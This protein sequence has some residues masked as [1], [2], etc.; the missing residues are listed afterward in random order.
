[1]KIIVGKNYQ[2]KP[3]LKIAGDS[4]SDAV[5]F[6]QCGHYYQCVSTRLDNVRGEASADLL[7]VPVDAVNAILAEEGNRNRLCLK[8]SSVVGGIARSSRDLEDIV[9][10]ARLRMQEREKYRT[11]AEHAEHRLQG[12]LRKLVRYRVGEAIRA[13]MGETRP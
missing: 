10:Q 8:L 1:M 7:L 11:R 2:G 12:G 9:V 4:G 3:V 5:A 6:L 13:L